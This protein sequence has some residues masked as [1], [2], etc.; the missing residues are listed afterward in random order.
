MRYSERAMRLVL[1][2]VLA[3]LPACKRAAAPASPDAAGPPG[4]AV[5]AC[6]PRGCPSDPGPPRDGGELVLHV[7]AEPAS[8][9]QLVEHDAWSR[10]IV[11]NQVGE[12]LLRQDPWTGALT[13][14]LAER[15]EPDAETGGARRLTFH[16]RRGVAWHDGKPFSARDVVFTLDKAR[17]PKVGADAR[18][19][20]API[21]RIESPDDATVILHLARPA[22]F[23]RQSLA[24]LVILPA[25]AF[26]EPDLR[27][28]PAARAPVGTG[29]FRFV[30]WE[31]G[32]E[33]VL[34]RNDQYWGE[35]A[36]LER[37][38][39]RIVRDKQVAFTLYRRGEID[40]LW[41]LASPQQ[42][43]EAR[44]DAGLA[45]H[46][47]LV[48]TP[49][50]YFFI[51]WNTARGPLAEKRVR[52]ALT[53]LV[54]RERFARIGFAGRARVTTGPYVPGSASYDATVAPFAF[55]PAAARQLL[56]EAKVEKLRLTFLQ[57]AGSRTV[58]QLGTL[59]KEDLGRAGIEV[60]LE[61]V[62][63][64]TLLDRLRR[65]AFD[66]S[67]LQW[68]LALEQDNY[69]MFHSS[70]AAGGQNYGSFKS[71]R[72][73]ALLDQIRATVDDEARHALDRE[74]HRLLHEE[75]PYTFLLSPEVHTLLGRRVRGLSPS[76]DGFDLARAWVVP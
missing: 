26:S 27:K 28:S 31:T 50:A 18:S 67:A 10:W 22:P 1:L 25:H 44:A 46:R 40:V 69:N 74:L 13:P 2:L 11:Q 33:I 49:R 66:A 24:H 7:E 5:V 52:Q 51:V 58:E 61:T 73:D 57:T 32:R 21:E 65:H 19:D 42:A 48:W 12:T 4:P 3:A 30:R 41:R 14:Q 54:D 23:L 47:M 43:E 17:D 20:L 59:L 34:A 56:A 16:L 6:G 63:F 76:T 55:D 71:A 39:Y 38:V 29:P 9:C 68:T 60:S 35:K 8:L 37:L 72:V 53:R 70:Q 75:L 15:L 64:A 45:G 62:D 36:H